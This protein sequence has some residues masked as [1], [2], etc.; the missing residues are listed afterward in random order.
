M[1]SLQDQKQVEEN[2]VGC[3]CSGSFV[4]YYIYMYVC[5]AIYSSLMNVC[6]VC[7]SVY[8]NHFYLYGAYRWCICRYMCMYMCVC[9]C[10]YVHV[11]VY[12]CL[13]VPGM[14]CVVNVC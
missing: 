5:L 3:K 2:V 9:V 12:I 7:L 10:V 14:V 6:S 11:H 13:S 1:Q 8:L 4:S